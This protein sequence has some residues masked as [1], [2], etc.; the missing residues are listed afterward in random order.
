MEKYRP[1]QFDQIV[2]S[3]LNRRLLQTMIDTG[4]VPH[5]L[6][7]GPPGTGKT[8]TVMNVIHS[9]QE[10]HDGRRN[11][12]LVIHLNASDDRGIDIIRSQIGQFVQSGTLFNKG[13]KFVILDEAD[14][15]TGGA[16]QALRYLLPSCGHTVRICLICNYISRLDE[17]LQNEFLRLRF[18]QLPESTIIPFLQTISQQEQLNLST[19]SLQ[20]IQRRYKSDIRSMINCMQSNQSNHGL[21]MVDETVWNNV[22]QQMEA[23]ASTTE[24]NNKTEDKTEDQ[25]REESM[26]Y[27]CC[28]SNLIQGIVQEYDTDVKKIMKDLLNHMIRTR[29]DYVQPALFRMIDNVI[30]MDD[31]HPTHFMN[32]VLLSL[33]ELNRDLPKQKNQQKTKQIFR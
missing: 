8:T 10:K 22:L 23:I 1:T 30:H 32:Y 15:M 28:L 13:M 4:Y 26:H 14:Y 9:Y 16:Q 20:Q 12:E 17:G 25:D 19:A 31:I 11:K 27:L 21:R 7:Y 3:P 24:N 29:P 6:F 18:N 33:K 2:L 5:L